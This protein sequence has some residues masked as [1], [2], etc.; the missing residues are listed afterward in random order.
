MAALLSDIFRSRLF[1]LSSIILLLMI[2]FL[3]TGE[4]GEDFWEHSAVVRELAT[5]PFSPNHPV[6]LVDMPH[7]FF[8]PYLLIVGLFARLV[9]LDSLQALFFAG[10]MNFV[11]FV[12]G[13]RYFVSTFV[14]HNVDHVAFYALLFILFFWPTWA[15]G[16]WSGFYHFKVFPYTLTYPATFAIGLT[17]FVLG[18]VHRAMDAR[19]WLSLVLPL[20]LTTAVIITHPT[21]ALFTFIGIGAVSL[22][23][24]CQGWYRAIPVGAGIVVGSLLLT[25][26]WPYY[27]FFDLMGANNPEFHAWSRHLYERLVLRLYALPIALAF[28]FPVIIARLRS[29]PGDALVWMMV[30]SL[31][32]YLLAPLVGMQGAGR[33]LSQLAMT[34]QILLAISIA[35]MEL[36]FRQ[37]ERRLLVPLGFI[38]VLTLAMNTV[39]HVN[40]RTSITAGLAGGNVPTIRKSLAGLLGERETYD[41]WKFL[42]N[43]VSQYDVVL[44]QL[45]TSWVQMTFGG[46][47]VASIH[48]VH[49][50]QDDLQRR[51][52]VEEFFAEF[53]PG[54]RRA[55]IVDHYCVDYILLRRDESLPALAYDEL[56]SEIYR[57][58]SFI[59]LQV[60]QNLIS[61]DCPGST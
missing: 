5:N 54:Q 53:T 35:G 34:L 40:I 26:V 45:K 59:L 37:G 41:D 21:T 43:Y 50:V 29:N 19:Q 20:V 13:L 6:L 60:D 55:E 52:D 36:R 16:M 57:S 31:A 30:G 47:S 38:A 24:F 56:T 3:L 9:S 49:W 11:L 51:A 23:F 61:S 10:L 15:A 48:P 4:R 22:H 7:A 25:V 32:V 18:S 27:S 1:Y 44:A 58:E 46:K 8:S 39:H 17:F 12:L 33:V 28:A 14:R 2:G 42:G